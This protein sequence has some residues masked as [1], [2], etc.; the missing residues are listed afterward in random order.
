MQIGEGLCDHQ[1][2]NTYAAADFKYS[3]R[4]DKMKFLE[5]NSNPMFVGFDKSCDYELVDAMIDHLTEP[6]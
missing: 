4:D 5:V 2:W 6:Q 3:S 1:G